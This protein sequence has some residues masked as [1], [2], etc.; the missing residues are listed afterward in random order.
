MISSS[1]GVTAGCR[2]EHL[3]PVALR[4][5]T[6]ASACNTDSCSGCNQCELDCRVDAG[7]RTHL[8]MGL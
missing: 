8:S 3:L 2:Q 6:V 7:R 5:A 4:C 1:R